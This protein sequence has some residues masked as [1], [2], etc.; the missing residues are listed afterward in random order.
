MHHPNTSWFN[1]DKL[2]RDTIFADM[3]IA[4][5]F[6]HGDLLDVGCGDKPYAPLFSHR[7]R[8][9]TGIDPRSNVADIRSDFLTARLPAGAFDTALSTQV[10]EHVSDPR[11]FLSGINRVLTKNGTLILTAPL[12]YALHEEPDDYFRFTKYGLLRLLRDTG[13]SPILI[14]EEGDWLSSL[15]TMKALYLEI[16]C[17]RLFLRYPKKLFVALLM[18][19]GALLSH[20]PRRIRK[21]ALFPMNYL[22]IARKT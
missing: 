4:S 10:L 7:V 6:A 12:V 22:V 2:I 5:S 17:N 15:I 16:T 19:L 11:K 13:F 8:S 21:P 3:A 1:P 14:K 9:Y 20:L 18:L